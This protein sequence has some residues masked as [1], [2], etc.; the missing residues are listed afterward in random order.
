MRFLL[1]T[2]VISE[3]L[4]E[5]PDPGVVEWLSGHPEDRLLLSALVVG[6]LV[7]GVSLLSP[8]RKRV[9]LETWIQSLELRFEGRII[10]LTEAECTRWG[11]LS[12]ALQRKGVSL[13]MADGLIAATGLAH[14]LTVV[15]RNVKDLAP[16]GVHL[17]NPWS[18]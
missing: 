15:T 13:S 7:R 4:R 18:A 2:C 8:G 11:K 3:M 14:K 1:D 9:S 6:E 17:V 5:R 12:G 16:T 10:A